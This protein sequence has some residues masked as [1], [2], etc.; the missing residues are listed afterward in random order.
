M[1]G[2]GSVTSNNSNSDFSTSLLRAAACWCHGE[3]FIF[4]KF[5][6]VSMSVV[7]AVSHLCHCHTRVVSRL[8][9]SD[10]SC[11]SS[12]AKRVAGMTMEEEKSSP[13]AASWEP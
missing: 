4:L 7:M 9:L 3:G 2:T 10:P 1:G 5:Q 6:E 13:L 12:L 8:S 11:V